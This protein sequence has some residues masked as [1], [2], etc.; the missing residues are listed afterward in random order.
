MQCVPLWRLVL[1]G[2]SKCLSLGQDDGGF[3][4]VGEWQAAL[5]SLGALCSLVHSNVRFGFMALSSKLK[6]ELLDKLNGLPVSLW[7]LR[8]SVERA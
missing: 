5:D 1:A 7:H 2:R 6:S 8:I 4:V 3:S